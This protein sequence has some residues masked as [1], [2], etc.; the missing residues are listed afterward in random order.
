MRY[1]LEQGEPITEG[2]TRIAVEQ[3]DKAL[4]ELNSPSDDP[5]QAMHEAR[6]CFKK[7]RALLRLARDTLGSQVYKV[8]NVWYRDAG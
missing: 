8:E 7:V 3:V 4:S 5:D 2:I 1:R 6:K